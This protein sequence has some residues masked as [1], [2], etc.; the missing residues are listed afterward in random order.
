MQ[1]SVS[2]I[3]PC[4]NVASYLGECLDSATEQTYEDIQ[5]IVVDDGSTDETLPMLRA[6]CAS[7]CR[8]LLIEKNNA[9]AGAARNTGL[10]HATGDYVVF[11]DS[12]DFLARDG[13]EKLVREAEKTRADITMGA[14]VKFNSKGSRIDPA[15]TYAEYRSGITAAEYGAVWGVIAI[16]GK[17]FRTSFI[18]KH[19]LAFPETFAQ[20]DF[21]FSYI[22]YRQAR[23]ITVLTEPVYYYRKRDSG[24]D[25][26]LTQGR[27]KKPSLIGRFVQ[28]ETT[29]ALAS[30]CDGKRATPHRRPFNLEFGKRLMRHIG[31]LAWAP[32]DAATHE[33]L[34]MIATFSYPY[35]A[36][37][38][39]HCAPTALRVYR[40][41]WERDLAKVKSALRK[42]RAA[43]RAARDSGAAT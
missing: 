26:S 23:R 40:A 21:S 33:A 15:H 34:E 8:I 9:G 1:P 25:E 18:R 32:D 31:K 35:R 14:R 2:I 4:Y 6:R 24:G 11:I 7:D 38:R 22:A 10:E 3:V 36:E 30:R 39:E 37:I 43:A 16:H 20:E 5:I 42:Q 41:V 17:L 12:D 13:I 28:V 27:L 19:N 29:L